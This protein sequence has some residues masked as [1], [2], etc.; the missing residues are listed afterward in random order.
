MQ[1]REFDVMQKYDFKSTLCQRTV[2]AWNRKALCPVNN[3][4]G[5][6]LH[7]IKLVILIIL[8]YT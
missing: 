1:N 2:N 3:Y 4:D 5:T 6:H 8:H 7:S